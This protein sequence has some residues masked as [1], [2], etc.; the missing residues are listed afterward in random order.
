MGKTKTPRYR[1]ELSYINFG[2]KRREVLTIEYKVSVHGKPT[3]E[4][5]R[6]LRKAFNESLQPGGSNEHLRA[7]QS[8]YGT[9]VIK[10]NTRKGEEI[11]RF[12]PPM[13]EE[14]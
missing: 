4:N 11:A 8:D 9:T 13:F 14:I 12:T 2:T 5:A 1:V 6:K 3:E 10:R 7:G